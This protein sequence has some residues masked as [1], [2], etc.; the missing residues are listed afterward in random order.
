MK[1]EHVRSYNYFNLKIRKVSQ[2]S[3]QNNLSKDKNFNIK[4]AKWAGKRQIVKKE[5]YKQ[6]IYIRLIAVREAR[7][8]NLGART[9]EV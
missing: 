4:I 8:D 6:Y 1:G 5:A 9:K 7:G 3:K 2:S